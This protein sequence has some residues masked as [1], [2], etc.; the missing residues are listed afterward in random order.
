MLAKIMCSELAQDLSSDNEVY[1]LQDG[2]I[3]HTEYR[4]EDVI[5]ILWQQSS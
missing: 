2:I 4:I 5:A 3:K 1:P